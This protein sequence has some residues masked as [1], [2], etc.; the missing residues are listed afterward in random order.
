M[1]VVCFKT[2]CI[3]P[4]CPSFCFSHRSASLIKTMVLLMVMKC[5]KKNIYWIYWQYQILTLTYLM[6]P[7]EWSL[8]HSIV[9]ALAYLFGPFDWWIRKSLFLPFAMLWIYYASTVVSK[10]SHIL[11]ENVIHLLGLRKERALSAI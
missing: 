4:K 11:L 8:F 6:S 7:W 1:H 2:F 5:I 3:L 10:R 9:V